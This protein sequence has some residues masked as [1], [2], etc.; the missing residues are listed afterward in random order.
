M[1]AKE[2]IDGGRSDATTSDKTRAD[3]RINNSPC[4]GYNNDGSRTTLY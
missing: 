2:L 1:L 3:A 4:N